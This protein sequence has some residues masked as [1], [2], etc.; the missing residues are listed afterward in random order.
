MFQDQ[1]IVR[2]EPGF[3]ALYNTNREEDQE[4]LATTE[5]NGEGFINAEILLTLY[6]IILGCLPVD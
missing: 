6:S 5:C 2:G 3:R 4:V 1:R